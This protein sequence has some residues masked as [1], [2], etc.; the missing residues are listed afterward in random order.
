MHGQNHC[1]NGVIDFIQPRL[2]RLTKKLD[3]VKL[4]LDAGFYSDD[5]LTF[6]ESYHNV[7]Y[8]IGTPQH[9][10]LILLLFYGLISPLS[11]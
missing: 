4:R 6:L 8:E 10:S 5:L 9:Q 11:R 2:D 7:I 3:L 1:S